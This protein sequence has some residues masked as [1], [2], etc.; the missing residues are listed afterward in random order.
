MTRTEPSPQQQ[1]PRP[2]SRETPE[3]TWRFRDWVAI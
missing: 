1:P 3:Q 2:P